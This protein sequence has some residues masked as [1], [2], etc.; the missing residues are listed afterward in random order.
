MHAPSAHAPAPAGARA[1]RRA[2]ALALLCGALGAALALLASG[3]VWS[4]ATASFAQGGLPVEAKGG[5]VTGLPSALALVGLAALV[6][7]FAVGRAVRVLVAALLTLC[8]TG[9][10][11]AALL[12][13]GDRAALEEKA[14]RASGLART[15]VEAVQ[16]SA[17]PY[18]SAAGGL[19]L[20]LAGV[21]ALRYGRAWPSMSGSARY[22]RTGR[23]PRGP[24]ASRGAPS[25]PADPDRPEDLWKALDR[26]EDPTGGTEGTSAR[27][28]G[29]DGGAA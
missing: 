15:G 29:A 6:A 1:A 5:D 11:A 18:V 8:G 16:V 12:G 14:A 9:A 2:L 25:A 17:W 24:R 7:V 26:G 21:L 3:Q 19:L 28:D 10:L 23:T 20:L 13:A 27:A 22:E 4:H